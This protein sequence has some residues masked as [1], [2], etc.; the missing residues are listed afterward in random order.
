[1]WRTSPRLSQILNSG[2]R[3]TV[4]SDASCIFLQYST[5]EEEYS[6]KFTKLIIYSIECAFDYIALISLLA[7]LSVAP[8]FTKLLHAKPFLSQN[9]INV[10]EVDQEICKNRMENKQKL[11]KKTIHWTLL[12]AHVLDTVVKVA[13]ESLNM[14]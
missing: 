6:R 2:Y 9:L 3:Y 5:Q 11:K 10:K 13:V 8:Y 1:M 7:S 14:E 4:H 12:A